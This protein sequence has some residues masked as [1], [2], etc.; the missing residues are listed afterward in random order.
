MQVCRDPGNLGKVHCVGAR[1]QRPNLWVIFLKLNERQGRTRVWLKSKYRAFKS[2][3]HANHAQKM[4]V[5][6]LQNRDRTFA[7]PAVYF[8]DVVNHFPVIHVGR[9]PAGA[10]RKSAQLLRH[11]VV[12]RM[13]HEHPQLS[14]DMGAPQLMAAMNPEIMAST[15]RHI[16]DLFYN[17]TLARLFARHNTPSPTG[18]GRGRLLGPRSRVWGFPFY[19]FLLFESLNKR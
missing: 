6:E 7:K 3:Y 17:K 19:F 10:L 18:A 9:Y 15:Y 13:C 2:D 8:R 12:M 11:A 4:V 1:C 16:D 5:R 14:S